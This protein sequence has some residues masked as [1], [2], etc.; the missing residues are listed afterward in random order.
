MLSDAELER[1]RLNWDPPEPKITTGYL[2]RYAALVTSANTG[3]VLKIK[4][5]QKTLTRTNG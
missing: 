1:R 4:S 2:A 5:P 3:G